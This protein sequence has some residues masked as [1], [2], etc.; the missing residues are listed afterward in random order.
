MVGG[1]I[2]GTICDEAAGWSTAPLWTQSPPELR[3]QLSG[4]RTGLNHAPARRHG[5]V[6][7]HAQCPAVP[8]PG[9]SALSP[10]KEK[11]VYP[12]NR[13]HTSTARLEAGCAD[14][15]RDSAGW[16]GTSPGHTGPVAEA[17]CLHPGNE[18][19]SARG[20]RHHAAKAEHSAEP[21]EQLHHLVRQVAGL[22]SG[23]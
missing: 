1:F 9:I 11:Y 7:E 18:A 22:P 12:T 2:G 15:A 17:R 10:V 20:D 19:R 14:Q 21:G 13:V 4:H 16:S 23:S 6:A 8:G 3:R 5:E